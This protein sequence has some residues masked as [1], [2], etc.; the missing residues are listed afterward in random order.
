VGHPLLRVL[1]G[2]LLGFSL[3][4]PTSRGAEGE[5]SPAGCVAF[6]R[7]VDGLN[8]IFVMNADGSEVRRLRLTHVLEEE[9]PS[10]SPDGKWIAFDSR[11]NQGWAIYRVTLDGSGPRRITPSGGGKWQP[12]WSPD[13]KRIAFTQAVAGTHA[14]ELFV[15][16]SD[17]SGISRL[18]RHTWFDSSD[19]DPDW[20]P[21]GKSI[22]FCSSRDGKS[23]WKSDIYTISA[24]GTGLLRLTHHDAAN[25]HPAWSPDGRLIAFDSNRTG[26]KHHA[27]CIMNADGSGVRTLTEGDAPCWKP[28]WSRDGKWIAFST[29]RYGRREINVMRLDGSAAH[30]LTEGSNP[31]WG[32]AATGQSR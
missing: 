26:E 12:A 30:R 27:I 7:E 4:F 8:Q 29:S 31:A 1:A 14:D 9:N 11:D 18:T 10:W 22:L 17:G 28:A 19:R 32:P 15:M 20:S 5:K 13:G 24:D 23:R 3:P 6:L 25:E 21:D 2:V 16:N